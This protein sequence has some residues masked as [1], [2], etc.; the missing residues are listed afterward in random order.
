MAEEVVLKVDVELEGSIQEVK[1]LKQQFT[2]AEDAVFRLAGAGKKNTKEFRDAS[3]RAAELKQEVD[4]INTSLDDLKPDVKLAAFGKTIGGLSS[5]FAA[6][7]GAAA[8]LGGESEDLQKTLVKVQ[9]AMAFSEGIRGLADLKEG[10]KL[11]KVVLITNPIFLVAT[12]IAAIGTAM[13]ALRNSI[14]FLGAA[15][16]KIGE[17]INTVIESLK[18]F[19]DWLGLSD[20]KATEVK[21]NI[22][23]NN[24]EIIKSNTERYDLEIRAAQR[25]GKATEDIEIAKAKA[26]LEANEKIKATLDKSNEEDLARIEEIRVANIE[27]NQTILDLEDKK[28]DKRREEILKA[29]EEAAQAEIE[30]EEKRL[31]DIEKALE[32]ETAAKEKAEQDRL[33]RL[34]IEE[35]FQKE[36]TRLKEEE[37]KRD[38][39]LAKEQAEL[40]ERLNAERIAR[41]QALFNTSKAVSD[42]IFAVKLGNAVK[43][44]KEEE[45]ILEKQF[46]VNKAFQLVNAGING[47]QA[48]QAIMATAVDPTGVTTAI[49]I[50]A[51]IATTAA[52]LAKIGASKF[53]KTASSAPTPTAPSATST[54]NVGGAEVSQAAPVLAQTGSTLLNPDGTVQGQEQGQAMVKAVVVE[55]DITNSQD[56][57]KDIEDKASFS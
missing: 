6:A 29:K 55:T 48:V 3:L 13:F 43:G 20:F 51:S 2:E 37:A 46:K 57:I 40:D 53:Q 9:A 56:N 33:D 25:A 10:F 34:A 30:A 32:I 31:S 27:L 23:A 4:N 11:L 14:P 54:P 15:F 1:D 47:V 49:R 16:D 39:E 12:A 21:N 19:S 17:T 42:G 50:A 52:N 7:T 24:E 38:E 44:S 41:N 8:L 22:I 36:V 45:K 35:A 18:Q 26:I 5:G 28:A